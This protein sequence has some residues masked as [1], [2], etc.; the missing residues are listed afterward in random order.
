MKKFVALLLAL[1]MLLVSTAS[2]AEE[3][4]VLSYT[5]KEGGYSFSYPAKMLLLSKEN[6]QELLDQMT[7]PSYSMEGMNEEAIRQNADQVRQMDM[8]MLMY[9]SGVFNYNVVYQDTGVQLNNDLVLSALCPQFTAQYKMI[10]PDLTMGDEG[11]IYT[12][13]DKEY[14]TQSLQLTANG[15][16]MTMVILYAVNGTY[17][18]NV[19]F[20]VADF[21]MAD[22]D[23]LSF[24]NGTVELFAS[25]FEPLAPAAE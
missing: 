3:A 24:M 25:S 4:E 7:D 20:T 10:Y 15:I 11:S 18:Y 13:G 22:A 21:A 5:N 6:V 14:V 17:L 1:L 8:V 19:T 16:P 23:F 9:A 2:L 12:L